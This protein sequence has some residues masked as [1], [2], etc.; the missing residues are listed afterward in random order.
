MLRP[1]VGITG[2]RREPP[3]E[4]HQPPA[5]HHDAPAP[6]ATTDV[7]GNIVSGPK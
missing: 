6:A 1:T 7:S 5:K 3:R 4:P 2:F